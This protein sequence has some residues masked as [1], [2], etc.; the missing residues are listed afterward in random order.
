MKIMMYYTHRETLGH[1]TR[2]LRIARC[3]Q[4]KGTQILILNGGKKQ[5]V[6]FSDIEIVNLPYPL[7]DRRE[8][9]RAGMPLD[10]GKIR[11]RLFIMKSIV[12]RF[13]PD[14]FLTE[15]FPFGRS[16]GKYEL[17]P[18]ILWMRK[19]MPETKICASIG[20]PALDLNRTEE[21]LE[22]SKGFDRLFI[23]TPE[24]EYEYM[25][26]ALKE[27]A[28]E[29]VN[30]F[31]KLKGKI[32]FTGY[33]FSEKEKKKIKREMH[34]KIVLVSR[35]GGVVYPGIIAKSIMSLRF[36]GNEYFMFVC[37]GPASTKKEINIFDKLSKGFKNVKT[38]SFLPNAEFTD[39]LSMCDVSV[40][41]CGY[42]TSVETMWFRKKAVLI[43]YMKEMEQVSR[44][45]MMKDL[46]G[47]SVIRYDKLSPEKIAE[48]IKKQIEKNMHVKIKNEW[49]NGL[50]NL[51]RG[52]KKIC[53]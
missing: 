16:E 26:V 40:S 51:Y 2:T 19:T 11:K 45:R 22:Y 9:Y 44:A 20:Y 27:K 15:F 28:E 47:S 30:F 46:L 1:T 7:R 21:I 14:L 42:N 3:L 23:H 35:G 33:V 41:M 10:T 12:K 25:K 38:F 8:F 24:I 4:S 17:Y 48:E 5:D 29:Y 52:L 36:L 53:E 18:F 32:I 31:R 43:P 13:K 34:K 37:Y 39:Y 50:E 49:Y 6:D